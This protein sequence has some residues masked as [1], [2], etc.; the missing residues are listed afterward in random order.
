MARFKCA[1]N[2]HPTSAK[3]LF[4]TM[5]Q[6]A[7]YPKPEDATPYLDALITKSGRFENLFKNLADVKNGFPENVDLEQLSTRR[8]FDRDELQTNLMF[9]T[10]DVVINKLHAYQALGVDHFIYNTSYGLDMARQKQSLQLFIDEVMPAFQRCGDT[11][12]PHCLKET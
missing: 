4:A 12:H 5:R 8:E 9:G 3:P 6:T 1:L 7:V 11:P 2:E 10:P